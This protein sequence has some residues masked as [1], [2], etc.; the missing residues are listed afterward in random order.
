MQTALNKVKHGH[1]IGGYKMASNA[2][3]YITT[4]MNTMMMIQMAFA[5]TANKEMQSYLIPVAGTYSDQNIDGMA[6]LVP[7]MDANRSYLQQY[8]S[9]EYDDGSSDE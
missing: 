7:D 4:D 6:V 9:G 5:L 3:P 8:M 2:A 1:L